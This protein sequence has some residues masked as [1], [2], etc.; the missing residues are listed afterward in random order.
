[1]S[2]IARFL[3]RLPLL[4]LL[5]LLATAIVPR[6]VAAQTCPHWD[7][8]ELHLAGR[9]GGADVTVYLDSGWPSR[10]GDDGVSGLVMDRARWMDDRD[11]A[12]VAL[13]GRRLD[14]CRLELETLTGQ[15]SWHLRFVSKDRVHGS[16]E[17]DGRSEA[18]VFRR[19]APFDCTAGPWKTFD[20]PRWPVTFD[21][22]ASAR[23]RSGVSLACPDVS[24]LAW[25]ATPLSIAHV[26]IDTS[27]LAD[28]RT[29]TTIGPFF[30]DGDGQWK[31]EAR[32]FVVEDEDDS[33]SRERPAG[34]GDADDDTPT[35]ECAAATVS[36]WRGF[37]VLH[38]ESSGEY[39][40]YRPGGGFYIGQGS[41]LT[42]YAILV[43]KDAVL[44]SS[45]DLGGP[46][47]DVDRPPSR[48]DRS[49]SRMAARVLRSLKR[50]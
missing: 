16:R 26:G 15:G 2:I 45:D 13:D 29:R 7:G 44:V 30:K 8:D 41:G 1:M 34:A 12:L 50:R 48:D 43:G 19:T 38:G 3:M 32:Q 17:I 33:C 39:R 49:T 42:Y 36:H 24:R 27:T 23:F 10:Q 28:G 21:Y 9:I 47:A 35:R 14:G 5:L 22:P 4:P 18:L 46:I 11:D 40:V 25:D 20:D 37:T 31:V 6:P